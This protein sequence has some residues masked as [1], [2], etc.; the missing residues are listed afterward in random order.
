MIT[1]FVIVSRLVEQFNHFRHVEILSR[2]KF[3]DSTMKLNEICETFSFDN[4]TYALL[5]DFPVEFPSLQNVFDAL[6]NRLV[7]EKLSKSCSTGRWCLNNLTQEDIRFTFDVLRQKGRSFCSLAKCHHR[8]SAQ[9]T[10]CPK[11]FPQVKIFAF[12]SSPLKTFRFCRI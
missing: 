5:R 12:I 1:P 6:V 10:A 11:L 4:H 8:L 7:V 2:M 3:C 9:I